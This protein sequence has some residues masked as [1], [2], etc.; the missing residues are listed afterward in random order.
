MVAAEMK[1][2]I[3]QLVYVYKRYKALCKEFNT[4]KQQDSILDTQRKV[5]IL[6][7]IKFIY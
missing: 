2:Y 6:M 5:H 1:S 7:I 4:T 3:C